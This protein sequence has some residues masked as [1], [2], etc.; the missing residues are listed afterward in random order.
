MSEFFR[1]TDVIAI[2][3]KIKKLGTYGEPQEK[4]ISAVLN[5]FKDSKVRKMMLESK[6][7]YDNENPTIMNRKRTYTDRNGVQQEAKNLANAK[8]P[9]PTVRK[10]VNQKINFI[11]GEDT[12]FKTDNE[13][14]VKVLEDFI[15]AKF[16][17]MIANIGR[18][19][20]TKGISWVQV[21]YDKLS[22]LRFKRIPAEQIYPFWADEDHTILDGLLRFYTITEYLASG[23]KKVITK[24]EYYT[25][26]G[27]W[28]YIQDDDGLKPD[29]DYA[30][31][32][33]ND[34]LIYRPEGNFKLNKPVLDDNGEETKD[35]DG[36]VM[37]EMIEGVWGKIPFVAFKYNSDEHSLLRWV[38]ALVD[39][40]DINTS[41]SSNNLQDLPQSVKVV[42]NYDGTS[43]EEFN[44]NLNVFRT[45]FVAGDGDMRNLD[46]PINFEAHESHLTRTRKDIYEAGNGVDTQA[47]DLGNQSGVG[48]KFR[49]QDLAQ[50][51]DDLATQFSL[52]LDELIWFMKVDAVNGTNADVMEA[53][54]DIIFSTDTIMDESA[55]IADCNKSIGV[56]SDETILSRHPWVTDVEDE[57]AKLKAKQ[58]EEDAREAEKMKQQQNSFG[59]TS[60]N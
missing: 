30:K 23:D 49:Y 35:A 57:L 55:T 7:Y 59:S 2:N 15:T 52:S 43:K 24:V 47:E 32:D 37:Y 27:V 11:L 10:L 42:K 31:R 60:F 3:N 22:N 5:E 48:L 4:F 9:H 54:V 8:L 19:A 20:I 50:D 6:E 45:A 26:E 18:E 41:D 38:K 40:Y 21:Y 29:P 14:L 51:C 56:V 44:Q 1:S 12:V 34:N 16:R 36:N 13:Q 58:E 53:D 17:L 28:Y 33:E 25:P 39:D 46:A